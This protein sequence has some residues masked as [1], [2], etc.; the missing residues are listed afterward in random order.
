MELE[1]CDVDP[2]LRPKLKTRV[3]SYRAEL[4]RLEKEFSNASIRKNGSFSL[5]TFPRMSHVDGIKI[6]IFSNHNLIFSC[7]KFKSIKNFTVKSMVFN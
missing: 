4:V 7:F 2:T 6:C 5:K 3:E 1:V